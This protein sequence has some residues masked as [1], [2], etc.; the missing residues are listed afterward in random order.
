MCNENIVF[1]RIAGYHW[2][3]YYK[4]IKAASIRIDG[5]RAVVMER[6]ATGTPRI[7]RS[8]EEIPDQAAC[9]VADSSS[10]VELVATPSPGDSLKS[11]NVFFTDINDSDTESTYLLSKSPSIQQDDYDATN[12]MSTSVMVSVIIHSDNSNPT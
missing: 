3:L 8:I 1:I 6:S 5:P 9:S 4:K 2:W 11:E 12:S 10:E 7:E